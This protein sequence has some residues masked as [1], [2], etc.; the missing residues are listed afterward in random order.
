MIRTFTRIRILAFRRTQGH[1]QLLEYRTRLNRI[2]TM[3]NRR[4]KNLSPWLRFDA[5][6]TT[7]TE[8]DITG[9]E[10]TFVSLT[11]HVRR[12]WQNAAQNLRHRNG[13]SSSG[14]SSAESSLDQQPFGSISIAENCSSNCSI[15]N[16]NP[17]V[18]E[19]NSPS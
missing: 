7:Q 8:G 2:R 6:R 11:M 3:P 18:L 12:I 4:S 15:T 5:R 10:A 19:E 17:T 1:K 9:V 14:K 16:L 13:T